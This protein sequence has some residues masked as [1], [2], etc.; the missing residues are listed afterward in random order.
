MRVAELLPGLYGTRKP[1][2]RAA[3]SLTADHTSRETLRARG[4]N[5][6]Y[7]G[8]MGARARESGR[9]RKEARFKLVIDGFPIQ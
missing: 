5:H 2:L 8:K 1:G 6:V 7:R 3:A 9:N 4:A